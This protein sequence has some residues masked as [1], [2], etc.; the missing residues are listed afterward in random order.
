D[1]LLG[2]NEEFPPS[3]AAIGTLLR[4][5]ATDVW[6]DAAEPALLRPGAT[7]VAWVD[8]Q[9]R[10]WLAQR[11]I[12]ALRTTRSPQ[13]DGIAA[14]TLA[15]ELGNGP[16]ARLL[17][18]RRLALH[19]AASIENGTRWVTLEVNSARTRE[20][21]CRQVEQFLAG[22]AEAGAF[23]GRERI[24]QWFVLCDERLYGPV[25][26]AAG[27]FRLVWGFQGAHATCRHSWLLEHRPGGSSTRAVS[28]NQ[29]TALG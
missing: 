12:N 14:C 19:L 22:Y 16:D 29:L 11:G 25:G 1:R 3:A 27:V 10:A 2:R 17:S 24:G 8:R 20:R 18:A 4:D 9:Q 21:A 6:N 15:G 26:L 23:A 7:P 28:L 5:G 13:P